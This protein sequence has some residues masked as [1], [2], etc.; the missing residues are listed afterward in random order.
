MSFAWPGLGDLASLSLADFHQ[1]LQAP[2]REEYRVGGVE[3]LG[4]I[5]RSPRAVFLAG[6][7]ATVVGVGQALGADEFRA[8]ERYPH[9]APRA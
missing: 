7:E 4:R 9:R 3:H 2:A 1:R 5:V 8:G 6:R